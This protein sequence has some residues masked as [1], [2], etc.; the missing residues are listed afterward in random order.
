[1]AH[2]TLIGG[3]AYE[4]KGGKTLV[5]GTAYSI[6]SGKTLVDGTAYEVGFAKPVMVTLEGYGSIS[7]CY[8]V[9]NGIQ[10][11]YGPTTIEVPSGTIIECY[12]ATESYYA[13]N[14]WIEVNGVRVAESD[15]QSFSAIYSH[16]VTCNI[17]V[18]MTEDRTETGYGK[19][20][21]GHIT[22]TEE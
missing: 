1:M 14:A 13:P 5:D 21:H 11:S 6:K 20:C 8:V 18:H 2:K 9:I 22:I 12:V 15:S 3:T 7:L 16:T 4:I 17:K 10:Y 19:F